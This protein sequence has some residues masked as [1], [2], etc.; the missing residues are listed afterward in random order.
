MFA[1][2]FTHRMRCLLRD[3]GSL[4]WSFAFPII[5][6]TFFSVALTG[7]DNIDTFSRIPVAVVDNAAY[8][9]DTTLQQALDTVSQ[10]QSDDTQALFSLRK[11]T[12]AQAD[13]ALK[14]GD[15]TGYFVD[16]EGDNGLRVVVGD[17]GTTQTI[18]K[19]FADQYL[20][21]KAAYADIAAQDPTAL[22]RA[23]AV[24]ALSFVR[25][26]AISSHMPKESTTYFYALIAMACLYGAFWGLKEITALQA[27]QS[28]QGARVSLA[29]VHKLQ[30]FGAS[31]C[32]ALLLQ[33]A[34]TALL[35]GYLQFVLGIQFAAQLGFVLLT[36]A[37]GSLAGVMLGAMMVVLIPNLTEANQHGIISMAA[38]GLSFLAGLMYDKMKFIVA[39]N[40]P[41]VAWLNPANLIADS[42]YS[43][44]YFDTRTRYFTD[45]AVLLALSAVMFA[46]VYFALRRQKYESI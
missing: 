1:T 24:K 22:Q 31:L 2:I 39:S 32:A 10:K 36:C 12:R 14:A 9:Q 33:T 5:L 34:S 8:Q 26:A 42:L 37:A 15:I 28:P 7:V 4:F 6:G 20:Q 29:P 21:T 25:S 38:V 3:R 44:Y 30:V 19:L 40:A 13:K 27:N 46:V 18:L 35:I 45:I 43:L 17:T 11:L 16:G 41:V 23:V